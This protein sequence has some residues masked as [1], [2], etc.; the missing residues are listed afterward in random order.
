MDRKS[1]EC[2]RIFLI[3][4][5]ADLEKFYISHPLSTVEPIAYNTW[6]SGALHQIFEEKYDS[7][8]Y[9]HAFIMREIGNTGSIV[10]GG[11]FLKIYP[12]RHAVVKSLKVQKEYVECI[13]D[14]IGEVERFCLSKSCFCLDVYTNP[15]DNTTQFFLSHPHFKYLYAS[16]IS[17]KPDV[18]E[19]VFRKELKSIYTGDPLDFHSIVKWYI[20][21]VLRATKIE[22]IPT[23]GRG[24]G[25]TMLVFELRSSG[26]E[27]ILAQ[28]CGL[29]TEDYDAVS[30][31]GLAKLRKKFDLI[32]I[33]CSKQVFRQKHSSQTRA[34]IFIVTRNQLIDVH[35]SRLTNTFTNESQQLF[36]KAKE[37]YAKLVFPSSVGVQKGLIVQIDRRVL[38]RYRPGIRKFIKGYPVGK[39][40][41][42]GDEILFFV[43]P[44]IGLREGSLIA[45]A[46][47]MQEP[48]ILGSSLDIEK[49]LTELSKESFLYSDEISRFH[50][51]KGRLLIIEF[52]KFK[53]FK[54]PLDPLDLFEILA[55]GTANEVVQ[56]LGY[57]RI[58]HIYLTNFLFEKIRSKA[59]G[60]L[61]PIEMATRQKDVFL[62]TQANRIKSI[63]GK[64]GDYRDRR[65]DEK[66]VQEFLLQFRDVREMEYV[67]RLLEHFTF[68]K[69]KDLIKMYGEFIKR[70][71]GKEIKDLKI[72]KYAISPL[73]GVKDS[74][75]LV[76][77]LFQHV[78]E[79]LLGVDKPPIYNL[80]DILAAPEFK[81]FD[82]I[83]VDD[84]IASGTQAIELLD[85][86]LG[87]SRKSGSEFYVAPLA[88]TEIEELKKRR[89][90]IYTPI[91]FERGKTAL[92]NFLQESG[93]RFGL[94]YSSI[95]MEE[96]IGAF[97]PRS[98]IFSDPR[99]RK[100]ALQLC[101]EI[102]IQ[103]LE[104][105]RG[106]WEEH[107]ISE[108]ALGYGNSQ[109]LFCFYYNCPTSA[110]TM[111]WK[112]GNVWNKPWKPLFPSRVL[113]NP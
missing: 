54:N 105:K 62:T 92:S 28:C 79:Q 100:Q 78:P 61:A 37:V 95:K 76:T 1:I 38:E 65:I 10:R 19:L 15:Q 7:Y 71:I 11:L 111:F 26:S 60:F 84:N 63:T 91:G 57:A 89:I 94:I 12:T 109:K 16:S 33:F 69:Q 102:G 44:S 3:D 34:G 80:S 45:T 73:G 27:T 47:V 108:C 67:C 39:E 93:I 90:H 110:I 32:F 113:K 85:Q 96:T 86:L 107:R 20:I 42:P 2:K 64:F 88:E 55:P 77:Y 41:K 106:R 14:L 40:L 49:D 59:S 29:L 21:E 23:H 35:L 104:D 31:E 72:V 101:K 5:A 30:K 48:Y 6:V 70:V 17:H 46:K 50:R 9:H 66:A 81:N 75:H 4:D 112:S 68:F 22:S 97:S 18:P 83:L 8:G 43:G 36:E 24:E 52:D 103:L 87:K 58:E 13:E 25:T 56:L 99:D 53:I 82:I 51:D 98:R 74:A